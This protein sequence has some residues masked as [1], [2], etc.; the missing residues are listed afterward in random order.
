MP[1]ASRIS[2]NYRKTGNRQDAN[3]LEDFF[4]L[5]NFDVLIRPESNYSIVPA[6]LHDYMIV[7]SPVE[8]VLNGKVAT[9]TRLDVSVNEA[10]YQEFL[11]NQKSNLGASQSTDI[12]SL[13]QNVMQKWPSPTPWI[14]DRFTDFLAYM[15]HNAIA[16]EVGVQGGAYA[17]H[18]LR[19]TSPKEL[20]LIDC[21]EQ[22]DSAI[23][24]DLDANVSNEE[25]EKLYQ[26]TMKR[27]SNNPEVSVIKKYSCDAVNLF[28]D[29]SLDWIYID[30]N[31]GYEAVKEDLKIWWP[32]LKKGGMISG[33]D[34]IVRES[35]GVVQA[36]NEFLRD[37]NLYF[38]CLTT[39]N[40]YDSWAI[41]KPI[42]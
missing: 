6:L 21:W 20:Y 11:M 2:F 32:K 9:I 31:H 27:F 19:L 23:Y 30:A 8:Y 33:H 28:A 29:E 3:V 35:F 7:C 1:E 25:Q 36:V 39:Q 24:D 5:F 16:V 14:Q 40:N 18:M 12:Q 17:E 42:K 4:S 22:Q 38:Y 13:Y 26:E 10:L 37:N 15:P 34:Y 41:A